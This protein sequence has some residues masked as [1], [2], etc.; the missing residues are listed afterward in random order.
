MIKANKQVESIRELWRRW[1]D[2]RKEW[3]N[4]AREDVDFYLGNHYTEQLFLWIEFIQLLSSL[5]QL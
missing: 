2:S 5:K 4:H 1:S 3:E